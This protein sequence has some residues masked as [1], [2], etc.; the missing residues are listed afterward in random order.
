VPDDAKESFEN[1]LKEAHRVHVGDQKPL[2]VP[3]KADDM[4][5][6]DMIYGFT[7][8][9]DKWVV[10]RTPEQF[11]LKFASY[12]RECSGCGD[13]GSIVWSQRGLTFTSACFTCVDKKQRK[14][15]RVVLE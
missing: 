10:Y 7:D 9:P 11:N 6:S 1:L 15:L 14:K 2:E 4:I 8:F 12:F 13:Q 3:T 5:F